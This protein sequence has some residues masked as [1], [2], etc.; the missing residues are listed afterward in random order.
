MRDGWGN[1]DGTRKDV[2]IDAGRVGL[3]EGAGGQRKKGSVGSAGDARGRGGGGEGG[4]EI[5][6]VSE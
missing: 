1:V 5:R 4:A 3:V 2:F 6:L